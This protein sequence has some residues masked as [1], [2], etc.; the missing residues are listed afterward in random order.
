M[1][2]NSIAIIAS[3]L[4]ALRSMFIGGNTQNPTSSYGKHYELTS[5]RRKTNDTRTNGHT[6]SNLPIRRTKHTP[7]DS[8][9]SLV[10][11]GILVEPGSPIVLNESNESSEKG[12]ITVKTT[13]ATHYVNG[14]EG[15]T[16]TV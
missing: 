1:V 5:D 2:E 15:V 3:S 7:H 14:V 11:G 9:D 6:A 10:T 8:E 4:P 16:S 13:I 12:R